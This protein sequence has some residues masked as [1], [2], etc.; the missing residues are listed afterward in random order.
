MI[1]VI[2]IGFF[3]V[4]WAISARLKSKFR[5]YS[6]IPISSGMSG[7]EAAHQMLRDHGIYD[8]EITA[9]PGRLTDHYDPASKTVNLSEEVY[10]GRNAAAVAVA[11]H[12]AGHAIQHAEA[13]GLL[14]FRTAMVPVQAASSKILNFIFIA[15]FV[16]ALF[17]VALP[18]KLMIL[19]IIACYGVVTLFSVITLPVELD[20][21]KRALAWIDERGVVTSR[22]YEMSKDALKWAALTYVVA[23]LGSLT[24]LAY[25]VFSFL[26]M[27]GD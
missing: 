27:S 13:Y 11:S 14:K 25:Y 4:S 17:F 23:A 10:H 16:S 18:Y 8:V 1:L 2:I 22:E 21:S 7:A 19:L 12:E 24:M 15:S 20:A 9:F 3:I 6:Q 5:K 26:G